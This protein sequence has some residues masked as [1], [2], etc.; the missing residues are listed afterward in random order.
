LANLQRA[1]GETV[2]LSTWSARGPL[3]IAKFEPPEESV[4]ALQVGAPVSFFPSTTGRVFMSYLP[5]MKWEH[6][7]PGDLDRHRLDREIEKII[8]EVRAHAMA[9]LDPTTLPA[10]AT[11]SAPVFDYEG[12]IKG[13]LS[14]VGPRGRFDRSLDGKNAVILHEA[15]CD[16]SSKLGFSGVPAI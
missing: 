4:Y 7:L 12:A 11:L 9:T 6:L 8:R 16:L 3:I 14:V 15:A 10:H 1:T 2:Y 13:T 5:R